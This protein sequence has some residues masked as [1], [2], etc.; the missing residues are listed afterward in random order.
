VQR[1][2][3]MT[4]PLVSG[5][6]LWCFTLDPLPLL[7]DIEHRRAQHTFQYP[8]HLIHNPGLNPRHGVQLVGQPPGRDY[9]G[10]E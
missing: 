7:I 1:I 10:Q 5:H 6:L 2:N 8:P 9:T 4:Y 3:S